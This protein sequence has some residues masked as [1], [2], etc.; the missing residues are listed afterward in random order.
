MNNIYIIRSYSKDGS[1]IKLGY[2]SNIKRRLRQYCYHN[3][4]VETVGEY[5]REDAIAFERY[6]HNKYKAAILNEW[7]DE[8]LLPTLIAEILNTVVVA[9]V[10]NLSVPKVT[11]REMVQSCATVLPKIKEI[12][13]E[14]V[15]DSIK[16]CKHKTDYYELIEDSLRLYSKVWL[17]YSYAKSMVLNYNDE[18][19]RLGTTVRKQFIKG[20]RYTAT[21]VNSKL[22]EVYKEY[23]IDRKAS[24]TDLYEFLTAKKVT[25]RGTRFI[26]ITDLKLNR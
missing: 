17:N 23:G 24:S 15:L 2:S 4:F 13:I 16:D 9:K 20:K 22:A 1:I 26:E 6:I 3:P 25:V 12:G 11:Y 19:K 14:G 10:E 5:F 18:Y 21:Q 8:S 7:Y